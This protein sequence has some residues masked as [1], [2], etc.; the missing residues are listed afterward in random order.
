MTMRQQ[1]RRLRF[2]LC[3]G[4]AFLWRTKEADSLQS[5]NDILLEYKRTENP[6]VLRAYD[7][8]L[9]NDLDKYTHMEPTLCPRRTLL[10]GGGYYNRK[11]NFLTAS[12]YRKHIRHV[13]TW[14]AERGIDTFI[15]DY[16]TPIGLL[17]L[18]TLLSLR[19]AGESFRLYAVRAISVRERKSYRLIRETP[20]E[21]I[22]LELNCD[23]TYHSP[24]FIEMKEKV[25]SK[26]GVLCNTEGIRI[27]REHLGTAAADF[28]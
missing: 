4:C 28:L 7:T 26:V 19:D 5:A 1:W 2:W 13:Y 9:Q 11:C 10:F 16:T 8:E 20:L 18:E 27:M 3:E 6:D 24:N 21:I 12:R 23:Y 14:A 25:Y 22:F 17:S 15:V